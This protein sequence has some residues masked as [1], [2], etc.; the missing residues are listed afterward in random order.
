[1]KTISLESVCVC[2]CLCVLPNLIITGS[3]ILGEQKSNIYRILSLL[4]WFL[5]WTHLGVSSGV[6]LKISTYLTRIIGTGSQVNPELTLSFT[7]LGFFKD[8]NLALF[9]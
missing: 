2:V 3:F 9:G 6:S 4:F 8:E 7:N 1:M 5:F